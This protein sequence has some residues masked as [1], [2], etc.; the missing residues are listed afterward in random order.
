MQREWENDK[1]KRQETAKIYNVNAQARVLARPEIYCLHNK[2][3]YLQIIHKTSFLA[4]SR[5][6]RELAARMK[7]E[8]EICGK[9]PRCVT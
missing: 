4:A 9:P 8:A 5:N 3:R 2:R 1:I 7:K 6:E